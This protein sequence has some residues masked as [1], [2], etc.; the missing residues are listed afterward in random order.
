M[1]AIKSTDYLVSRESVIKRLV[2]VKNHR[3]RVVYLCIL[4]F[5]KKKKTWREVCVGEHTVEEVK[6]CTE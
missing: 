2:D 1:N 3:G 4:K 5:S 6:V